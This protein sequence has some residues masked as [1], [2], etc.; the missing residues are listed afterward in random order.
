[1]AVHKRRTYLVFRI[2]QN[3]N[4]VITPIRV[5]MVGSV[6]LRQNRKFFNKYFRFSVMNGISYLCQVSH[7]KNFAHSSNLGWWR[8]RVED[9]SLRIGTCTYPTAYKMCRMCCCSLNLM[10]PAT[11]ELSE[12]IME[13]IVF[14]F[15]VAV[16][17]HSLVGVKPHCDKMFMRVGVSDRMKND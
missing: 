3:A 8:E 5:L 10:W 17:F 6:K 13:H 16:H 14:F 4:A 1:M 9:S 12:R 11:C 15:V 7:S 2:F